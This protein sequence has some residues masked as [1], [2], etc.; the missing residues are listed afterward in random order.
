MS[1]LKE[2]LEIKVAE[3]ELGTQKTLGSFPRWERIVLVAAILLLIP[4]YFL[5]RAGSRAYW[6]RQLNHYLIQNHPAFNESKKPRVDKIVLTRTGEEIYGAVA[7]VKNENLDLS[8][9]HVPYRFDFYDSGKQL[10]HQESGEV[11]FL[12]NDTKYVIVPHLESAREIISVEFVLPE[13]I[14]WQRKVSLPTVTVTANKPVTENQTSPVAFVIEGQVTNNS[15][16]TIKNVKL[17]IL[18]Y[19]IRGEIIGVNTRT[20][21]NI[22]PRQPRSYRLVWPDVFSR[23]VVNVTVI[24]EVN[25]IDPFNLDYQAPA[26]TPA[27]GLDR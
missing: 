20:E 19:D 10:V 18:L 3:A 9:Q 14:A 6:N 27:S 24:P 7:I 23:D 5:A 8:A 11:F 12:P 22:G 25:T 21:Q 15:I 2:K 16:Y 4:A 1:L 13:T 26:N 17:N